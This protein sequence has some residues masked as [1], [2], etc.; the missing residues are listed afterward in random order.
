[1]QSFKKSLRTVS[2]ILM[3]AFLFMPGILHAA[4]YYVATTGNDS[5]PG[6]ESSPWKTL[7]KAGDK[8]VAGDTV[9]IKGGVYKAPLFPKNSG[10]S[11]NYISFKGVQGSSVIIEGGYEVTGWS[12]HNGSI[13][14]ASWDSSWMNAEW[15]NIS[16]SKGFVN[17]DY[18][19]NADHWPK[20]TAKL[21]EMTAGSW[22]YDE[23]AK[24]LFLWL[25]DSSNPNSHSVLASKS[26]IDSANGILI[27]GRSYLRFENLHIRNCYS[28]VYIDSKG[29]HNIILNNIETYGVHTGIRNL[30]ENS[31]ILLSKID[32]HHTIGP[33][34]QN[35]GS[36]CTITESKI[37]ETGMVEWQ[38]WGN[39]GVILMGAYNTL[40]DSEI[41][42]T[43]YNSNYG[44]GVLFETWGTYGAG[45]A[46]TSHDNIVEN[47]KIYNSPNFHGI[48]FYGSDNCIAKRNVLYNM[49]GGFR[50]QE[51]GSGGETTQEQKICNNSKIYNNSVINCSEFGVKITDNCLTT[52]IFNNI[53]SQINSPLNF[54]ESVKGSIS[55]NY[56]LFYP[57][58]T[59]RIVH[60][61][62]TYTSLTDYV[63]STGK[64]QKSLYADPLFNNPANFDFSLKSSSPCI[65]S[66][67]KLDNLVYHNSPD[68]GAKEFVPAGLTS[69]RNLS[70]ISPN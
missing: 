1:M 9:L 32:V 5:N 70:V 53:F 23:S 37:H 47:C 20:P 28:G 15:E 33:G 51:G 45:G 36:N 14:S 25:Q 17:I 43:G 16:G 22:F 7:K 41:Y 50:I 31:N 13:Y 60:G 67:T 56:N 38:R 44:P 4:T 2:M 68:M 63:K 8:A 30:K 27:N 64:D 61:N 42:N 54:V 6:T 69:P 24:K 19:L 40:K 66:G 39:V 29:S 59:L 18:K 48:V 65:D 57:G 58:N 12:V 3:S 62:A 34:I 26:W 21:D 46:D 52:E 10:A 55:S 49:K 11:A 35:N